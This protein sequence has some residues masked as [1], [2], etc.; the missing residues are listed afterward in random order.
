MLMVDL[1]ELL[2]F[3]FF[4]LAIYNVVPVAFSYS[5]SDLLQFEQDLLVGFACEVLLQLN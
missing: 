5:A 1:M 2:C 4:D 3:G